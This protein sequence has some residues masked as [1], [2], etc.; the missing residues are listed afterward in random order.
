MTA[1]Y[2]GYGRL[3]FDRPAER[4]L[5][6]TMQSRSPGNRVD[7]LMHRELIRLWREADEDRE[8]N[9]IILRSSGPDFCP[10]GQLRIP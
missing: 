7:E 3:S 8:I 5:R 10:W 1:R 6:V 2:Q 4:V 9:A